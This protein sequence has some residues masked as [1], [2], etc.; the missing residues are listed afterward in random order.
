MN[1]FL[2]RDKS[3]WHI[4]DHTQH[5]PV[6]PGR[7]TGKVYPSIK[8]Q[9]F[10]F[11]LSL[12]LS[13]SLSSIRPKLPTLGNLTLLPSG[14]DENIE[15]QSTVRLAC[16][17]KGNPPIKWIPVSLFLSGCV[18]QWKYLSH[19]LYAITLA[20]YHHRQLHGTTFHNQHKNI[21][22]PTHKG[23]FQPI[24]QHLNFSFNKWPQALSQGH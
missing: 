11:S 8:F 5:T 23:G 10:P 2:I 1:S 21:Y 4:S 22:I 6:L 19:I 16:R 7:G 15:P 24:L 17:Y 13:L 12:S 9:L 14:H 18:K 3:S 20:N